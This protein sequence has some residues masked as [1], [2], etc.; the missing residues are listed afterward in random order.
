MFDLSSAQSN[1]SLMLSP[2]LIVE[3]FKKVLVAQLDCS[4]QPITVEPINEY[5]QT[6]SNHISGRTR[7]TG[8]H[9][10]P[11]ALIVNTDGTAYTHADAYDPHY[12]ITK[13]FENSFLKLMESAGLVNSNKA[14]AVRAIS[15][16]SC[17]F[18]N[19][20]TQSPLRDALLS[21]RMTDSKGNFTCAVA[22]PFLRWLQAESAV[23][24]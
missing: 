16:N 4:E 22:Q 19:G 9:N 15:C 5:L 2:E 17:E 18:Q 24:F 7:S 6:F 12:R 14:S 8:G 21:E 3:A 1:S 23:R 11:W 10:L 13:V 20:C